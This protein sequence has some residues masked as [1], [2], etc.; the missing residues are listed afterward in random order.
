MGNV[1][2]IGPRGLANL[3]LS[4]GPVSREEATI[5]GAAHAAEV[6]SKGKAVAKKK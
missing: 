5:R 4:G 3:N 6:A 1:L 2:Y